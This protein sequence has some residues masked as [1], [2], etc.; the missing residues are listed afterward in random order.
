[1]LTSAADAGGVPAGRA[2]AREEPTLAM[3]ALLRLLQLS[4]SL[5]PIG[6]FAY[7]QGLEAAYERGWV[8]DEPTLV[9]W[10]GGLAQRSL[11]ALDLPIVVRVHAAFLEGDA[12]AAFGWSELL[13]AHREARE[14][15]E[16]DE[17]LGSALCGVL[18]TL[19][20][21]EA[22]SFRGRPGVSYAFAYALGAAR[23]GIPVFALC[24]GYAY[25]WLEQQVAAATRLMPIGHMAAQRVLSELLTHVPLVVERAL[26]ST[27]AELGALT[28]TLALASAWHESQYS[29]LFR[30]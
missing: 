26:A 30:S 9:E 15:L 25:A 19:G 18:D 13:L 5:L 20:I 21:T 10:I 23:F 4:S 22:A 17:Q 16:Q 12:E 11:S 6:A 3:P 8:H 27:D 1:M 7:S 2:P 14:L 28:P 24:H 29:R